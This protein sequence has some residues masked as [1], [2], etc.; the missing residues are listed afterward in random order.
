MR[1]AIIGT[2][3]VGSAL[4]HQMAGIKNV[5][6][7]SIHSRKQDTAMAAILDV[8]SAHPECALQMSVGTIE[9]LEAAD[10]LVLT[11]GAQMKSGQSATDVKSENVQIT[12]SFFKSFTPKST[13]LVIALAT[14]VDDITPIV[15]N[16]SSL[17]KSQVF[18]FGG[19]LDLNRLRYILAKQ[20]RDFSGH[21]KP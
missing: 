4:I 14:P 6:H 9:D 8:A 19:D 18:G 11:S 3:N 15:Q 13:A 10:I 17:P 2:G 20:G 7:I 1:V 12:T 16:I 5:A 21:Y